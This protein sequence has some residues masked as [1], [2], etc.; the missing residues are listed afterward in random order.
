[1]TETHNGP[2]PQIFES[3]CAI[4]ALRMQFELKPVV[5]VEFL[6]GTIVC[7][8]LIAREHAFEVLLCSI[9]S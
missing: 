5:L 1:M 4:F 7:G 6:F 2:R 8:T 9:V 3:E